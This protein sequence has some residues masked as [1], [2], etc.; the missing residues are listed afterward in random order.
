MGMFSS[1]IS[2]QY[3]S[4]AFRAPKAGA[5]CDSF[6]HEK[7]ASVLAMICE[8]D[9]FGAEYVEMCFT[10]VKDVLKNRYHHQVAI[11][12]GR[13]VMHGYCDDCKDDVCS[14]IVDDSEDR[15]ICD[16]VCLTHKAIRRAQDNLAAAYDT[17]SYEQEDAEG[18]AGS[19]K[20]FEEKL[21]KSLERAKA[22]PLPMS[23]SDWSP[24][25]IVVLP[26][27]ERLMAKFGDRLVAKH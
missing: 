15:S 1:L 13:S 18:E 16:D 4:G 24:K 12:E 2:S 21:K 17:W 6:K 26:L 3:K 25:E 22:M 23:Y 19:F 5:T 7:R 20:D 14:E 9:S 11:D 27:K 10:C 8:I